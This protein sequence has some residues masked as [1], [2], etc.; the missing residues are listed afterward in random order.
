MHKVLSIKGSTGNDYLVAFSDKSGKLKASCNCP[1]GKKSI[2]CKHVIGVMLNDE[3]V[4]REL[5][6]Y[7]YLS[8]YNDYL[9]KLDESERIKKEASNIKKK[10]ERLLLR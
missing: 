8:V 1:A 2:L 10:F 4:H 5:D 3:D 9:A 6:N 7:G